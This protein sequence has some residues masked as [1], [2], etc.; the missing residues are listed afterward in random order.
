LTNF[1]IESIKK[2][3]HREKPFKFFAAI[4]SLNIC[5]LFNRNQKCVRQTQQLLLIMQS[6][7]S[8]SDDDVKIQVA[9]IIRGFVI[10]S[11][12]CPRLV[13]CVQNWLPKDISLGY[14]RILP[15]LNGNIDNK[16][17]KQLSLA[18]RGVGIC[19]IF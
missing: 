1:A 15:F 3:Q 7:F 12:D 4:V 13:N 17:P 11:F 10:H 19:G 8:Y 16:M 5:F 18:I 14:P 2:I 9:L 6:L